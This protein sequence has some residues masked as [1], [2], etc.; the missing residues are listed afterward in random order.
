MLTANQGAPVSDDQHSL[1]A[2]AR[3]P[4]LMEDFHFRENIFHFDHERI[5]ER[6]VHARGM[7]AHGIF[8]TYEALSD[9]TVGDSGLKRGSVTGTPDG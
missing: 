7:G 1:K 5:P 3:D 6:V 8:E 4:M 9:V 2:G